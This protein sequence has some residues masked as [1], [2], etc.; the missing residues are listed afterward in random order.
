MAQTEELMKNESVGDLI[1][2]TIRILEKLILQEQAMGTVVQ[3]KANQL[4][5]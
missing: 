3:H 5:R 2:K 1:V 4:K